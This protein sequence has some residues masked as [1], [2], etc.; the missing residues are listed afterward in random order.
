MMNSPAFAQKID[1]GCGIFD[2]NVVFDKNFNPVA[3]LDAAR[4]DVA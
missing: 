4:G 1:G 2:Q 3:A